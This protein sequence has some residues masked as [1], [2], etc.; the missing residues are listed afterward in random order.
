MT[1]FSGFSF[2]LLYC[3]PATIPLKELHNGNA[4]TTLLSQPWER[5]PPS[6]VCLGL[7]VLYTASV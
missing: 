1:E 4:D 5:V 6:T 3:T 7:C 2:F